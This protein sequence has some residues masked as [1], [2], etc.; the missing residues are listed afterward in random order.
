MLVQ[1]ATPVNSVPEVSLPVLL[2]IERL[3]SAPVERVTDVADLVESRRGLAV[4]A[5]LCPGTLEFERRPAHSVIRWELEGC[6]CPAITPKSGSEQ[7]A[8]L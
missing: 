6:A 4:V 1:R 2:E 5:M 3:L 8:R 7:S